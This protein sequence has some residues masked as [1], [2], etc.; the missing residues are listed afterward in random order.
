VAKLSHTDEKGK[1]RM[2]DVGKKAVTPRRAAASVRVRMSPEALAAVRENTLKKGDV[3]GVARIAGIL[4]AKKV[5]RLIPLAHPLPIE[6]AGV[7]FDFE[8]DALLIRAEVAVTARTGVEL[9]ALTAAAVA[10][11]TVYDMAK[12]ADRA[13][14]I[15]DLRLDRKS[16]GRS[17][18]FRR[19]AG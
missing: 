8:N 16:G 4:A 6:Y 11:L 14:E 12:S 2:V 3:L 18:D 10:A 15:T 13:M 7:E 9:E 5:D 19:G 1:A 17:G